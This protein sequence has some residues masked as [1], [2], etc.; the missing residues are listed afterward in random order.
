MN[1]EEDSNN[2]EPKDDDKNGPTVLFEAS[3]RV[4]AF[5]QGMATDAVVS[6]SAT[7]TSQPIEVHLDDAGVYIRYNEYPYVPPIQYKPT[8]IVTEYKEV[9]SEP[10]QKESIVPFDQAYERIVGSID[11][12]VSSHETWIEQ[13]KKDLDYWNL[14]SKI[15]S[16]I[17]FLIIISG[18][19]LALFGMFAL[20][21][22]S[23]I[24][25]VIA[26]AV[27]RLFFQQKRIAETRVDDYQQQLS[28]VQNNRTA[29]HVINSIPDEAQRNE[30]KQKFVSRMI[31][32]LNI[33]SNIDP[34]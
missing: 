33:E 20:G 15:A 31:N 4:P 19:L 32:N 13:A 26:G 1:D 21:G 34:V 28:S 29:F 8:I 9:S 2:I 23:L 12:S 10:I 18:I 3:D 22:M 7:G 14:L 5:L 30:A 16:G 24:Y 25:G 11:S 27:A 17:G 6:G